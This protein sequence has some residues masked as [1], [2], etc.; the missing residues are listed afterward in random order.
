MDRGA[1]YWLVG[2]P[3]SEL[4]R[5]RDLG[6]MFSADTSIEDVLCVCLKQRILVCG[7]KEGTA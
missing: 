3:G 6:T 2:S 5:C 4:I 1:S 7:T